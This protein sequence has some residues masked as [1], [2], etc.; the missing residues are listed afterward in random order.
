MNDAD[1]V[2]VKLFRMKPVEDAE[3]TI[4][5]RNIS[6]FLCQDGV[7]RDGNA[8]DRLLIT[9]T[10]LLLRS[11]WVRLQYGLPRLFI[12]ATVLFDEQM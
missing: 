9:Q 1:E 12:L 2:S 6:S 7:D 8:A 11:R 5:S 4:C 10:G 3:L